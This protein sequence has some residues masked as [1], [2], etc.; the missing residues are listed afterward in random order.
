MFVRS[1]FE[2][3]D[4]VGIGLA[5]SPNVMSEMSFDDELREDGLIERRWM[6]VDKAAG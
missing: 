2:N 3:V 1:C 5:H 6:A 4:A